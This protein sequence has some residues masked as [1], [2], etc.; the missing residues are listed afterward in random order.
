MPTPCSR[1]RHAHATCYGSRPASPA[2]P[3]RQPDRQAGRQP[4]RTGQQPQEA[5]K[6]SRGHPPDAS[7]VRAARVSLIPAPGKTLKKRL[8]GAPRSPQAICRVATHRR[9]QIA[10][11]QAP[12]VALTRLHGRP[13]RPPRLQRQTRQSGRHRARPGVPAAPRG[14][15]G[16]TRPFPR[17]CSAASSVRSRATN[18]RA[19]RTPAASR[20]ARGTGRPR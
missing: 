19:K 5:L 16:L 17:G 14:P 12:H 10:A 1:P 13:T 9:G 2:Q 11:S 7:F 15:H 20:R 18:L 4:A 6:G 8:Q 3:A